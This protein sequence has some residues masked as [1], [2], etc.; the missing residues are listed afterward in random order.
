MRTR[1]CVRLQDDVEANSFN[2]LRAYV[3]LYGREAPLK[4]VR[5]HVCCGWPCVPRRTASGPLAA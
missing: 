2:V 5:G 1:C 4:L 3:C